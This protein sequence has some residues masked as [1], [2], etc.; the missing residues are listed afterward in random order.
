VKFYGITQV[1]S[2]SGVDMTMLRENLKRTVEE[3]WKANAGLVRFVDALRSSAR[4]A[5]ADTP[6][7]AGGSIMAELDA[8]GILRHLVS[9]Q[10]EFVLIG[11]M[12]MIAQGATYFTKDLDI[13]Y[14]RSPQNLDAVARAFTALHCYLRGVPP[15]LPF[16]LDAPTIKAGLNFTLIT[17]LG[18][19]DLL[20]EV[21]GVGG[22]A[23]VYAQ[24]EERTIFGMTF[25]VLSV[26]GLIAAKKAAGRA[27]DRAHLLELEELKKL[28]DANP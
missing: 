3:R 5:A 28:R 26:D 12:A 8:P 2:D 6:G 1:Y 18:D 14:S 27:K 10:V 16:R 13:C 22:F 7:N 19:V 23:E 9:H 25:P 24:S 21:A 15:G 4:G 11:G 20:G 17:D